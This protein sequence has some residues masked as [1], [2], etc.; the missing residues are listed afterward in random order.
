MRRDAAAKRDWQQAFDLLVEAD[1]DGR[2]APADLPVRGW[3]ARAER[4]LGTPS[5]RVEAHRVEADT[6]ARIHA[7][8]SDRSPRPR[9]RRPSEH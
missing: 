9:Q 8:T 1:A 2:L 4:L 5:A 6:T 7:R 3:L